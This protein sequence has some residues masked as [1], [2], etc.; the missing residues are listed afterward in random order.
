MA[1]DGSI[2]SK[3]HRGAGTRFSFENQKET[4]MNAAQTTDSTAK[5]ILAKEVA[6]EEHWTE[7]LRDGTRVKIRPIH[8]QDVELER[9]FIEDLSPRSRHFRF[10]EAMRSPGEELLKQLTAIDPATAVA[11][12]ALVAVGAEKREVGVAR[13]SAEPGGKNCEF[14]VTVSDD[15]QNR[16]LGTLLMRHL[17]DAARTRGVESMHSSDAADNDLMRKFAQHLGLQHQ[18]D[19]NDATQVRYSLDV[20]TSSV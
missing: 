18:R 14:A 16:G 12:V 7:V 17:V 4:T 5:P 15:W 19:P 3:S 8:K 13:F 9:R 10:L 6:P 20:K 1:T 2:G 11:Y